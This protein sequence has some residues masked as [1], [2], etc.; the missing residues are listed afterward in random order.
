MD[1]KLDTGFPPGPAD[2]LGHCIGGERR[3]SLAEVKEG[4]KALTRISHSP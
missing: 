1:L 4:D 3:L 2:D